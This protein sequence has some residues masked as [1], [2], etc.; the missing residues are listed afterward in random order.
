MKNQKFTVEL[1]FSLNLSLISFVNTA[2]EHSM[3]LIS[4]HRV[5]ERSQCDV[6]LV[7]E[8]IFCST[9]TSTPAD[10]YCTQCKEIICYRCLFENHQ[11]HLVVTGA[12]KLDDT[13]IQ[14]K[15]NI[16]QLDERISD[17]HQ[18]GQNI[19][20][21]IERTK[22]AYSQCRDEVDS[23]AERWIAMI[24]EEQKKLKYQLTKKEERQVCMI[25]R[26]LKYCVIINHIKNLK[27]ISLYFFYNTCS[28]LL[29]YTESLCP[30]VNTQNIYKYILSRCYIQIHKSY[31]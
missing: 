26:I 12:K 10:L 28:L 24:K 25:F 11:N 6:S 20:D 22:A 1:M 30:A 3:I 9:H 7:D 2:P 31:T 21:Q 23:L 15:E 19:Q 18:N 17:I 27:L 16:K 4:G 13:V 8:L 14:V 5:E 29:V